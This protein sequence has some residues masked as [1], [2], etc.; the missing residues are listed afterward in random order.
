MSTIFRT[1]SNSCVNGRQYRLIETAPPASDRAV[2]SA[3]KGHLSDRQEQGNAVFVSLID[4]FY[5]TTKSAEALS[6]V[7]RRIWDMVLVRFGLDASTT[8]PATKT[9]GGKSSKGNKKQ[10]PLPKS[11]S[12]QMENLVRRLRSP[13]D[14]APLRAGEGVE[15]HLAWHL[16]RVLK[17]TTH[18]SD[19]VS[20]LRSLETILKALELHFRKM[21]ATD[22]AP[23]GSVS[24]QILEDV[25]RRISAGQTEQRLEA[26]CDFLC[27]NEYL[28]GHKASTVCVGDAG[29]SLYESQTELLRVMR[30]S[31]PVL[32]EYATP[33][34]TGKSLMAGGLVLARPKDRIVFACVVPGV[35]LHVA[36][37]W[38]HL[39]AYPTFVFGDRHIEPS[40]RI[41]RVDWQPNLNRE[42][43][44]EYL[45]TTL[46]S[47]RCFVCDLNLLEWFVGLLDPL[48][49]VV[50]L[51]EPTIG[52]DGCEAFAH[53]PGLIAKFFQSP[54]LPS[55]VVVSSATL[56]SSDGMK[57]LTSSWKRLYPA[58]KV[59]RIDPTL[60][61]SSITII[62]S[63]SGH[64]VLPH[65]LCE[66]R[67]DVLAL[68]DEMDSDI[69]MLKSY[70]GS[71]ALMMRRAYRSL[72][73]E[74][75]PTFR[76]A[77]LDAATMGIVDI[78]RYVKHL[79]RAVLAK[80]SDDGTLRAFLQWMPAEP[81]FPA[82]ALNTLALGLSPYVPGQ[83][84]VA[85]AGD[86][87]TV[88]LDIVRPLIEEMS[89]RS[90]EGA[91]RHNETA[92]RAFADRASKITDPA[93]RLDFEQS[94]EW[95]SGGTSIVPDHLVVHSIEHLRRYAPDARAGTFPKTFYR[96]QPP[97]STV[98]RVL[99]LNCPDWVKLS[100]LSGVVHTDVRLHADSSSVLT[101]MT[102]EALLDAV[103]VAVVDSNFVYGINTPASN[104]LVTEEFARTASRNSIV[105]LT[106]RVNRSAGK[107][108]NGRAFLCEAAIRQ[109][110]S[111]TVEERNREA[112][113]LQN[114]VDSV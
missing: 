84:L 41:S 59:E 71:A 8:K 67:Q 49:T 63:E 83:T 87:G 40:F 76:S 23:W 14:T 64:I 48:T 61:T 54:S 19:Y 112:R 79:L 113:A 26:S 29:V 34:S 109:L 96:R 13:T 51:D 99:D 93:E 15:V 22:A 111:P 97:K 91:I 70:S 2:L 43:A 102:E 90:I 101:G 103:P 65:A 18:V 24:T 100:F 45:R 38:Y 20:S 74:A 81:P 44:Q 95:G 32:V 114:A 30:S 66:S 42:T 106:N 1:T 62:A 86:T 53:V 55:R 57:C 73:H 85:V 16:A 37:L 82:V 10:A 47:A 39:G 58:G 60:L 78:R 7:H 46:A 52:L 77:G 6:A 31:T 5:V 69:V 11:V 92:E 104:V 12:I 4:P 27:R 68:L 25:R 80:A 94:A 56:P 75:P 28:L 110:F 21:S 35:Y 108:H 50:F 33:P 3:I 9:D 98:R 72:F 107:S 17:P 105:Q 88:A 36:R 89:T